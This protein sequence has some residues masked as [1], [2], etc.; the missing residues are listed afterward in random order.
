MKRQ[1]EK[2]PNTLNLFLSAGQWSKKKKNPNRIF[3]RPGLSRPNEVKCIQPFTMNKRQPSDLVCRAASQPSPY[4][5]LH[6]SS[7]S[8][9]FS[10]ACYT[11]WGVQ[12]KN[13][14]AQMNFLVPK[15]K[16]LHSDLKSHLVQTAAQR[17]SSLDTLTRTVNWSW[18]KYFLLVLLQLLS[19]LPEDIA[20]FLKRLVG[21]QSC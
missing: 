6:L 20:A 21:P 9:A 17:I 15:Q 16:S 2:N 8:S 4:F 14:R 12:R 10:S 18:W 19:A 13:T 5:I 3:P 11:E 1:P 7:H